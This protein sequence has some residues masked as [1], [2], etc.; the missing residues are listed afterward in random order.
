[1]S[2][3]ISHLLQQQLTPVI[4]KL[5]VTCGLEAT[6][7]Y[8]GFLCEGSWISLLSRQLGFPVHLERNHED[9]RRFPDEIT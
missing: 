5:L 9:Y 4:S 1:M 6:R 3:K 7:K 2:F 8:L